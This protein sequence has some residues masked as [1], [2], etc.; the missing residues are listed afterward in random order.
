MTTA[1]DD[2]RVLLCL[3]TKHYLTV[4]G[5]RIIACTANFIS[6][7]EFRP[8]HPGLSSLGSRRIGT[9]LVFQ[10]VRQSVRVS[11]I[12]RAS[13]PYV[14]HAMPFEQASYLDGLCQF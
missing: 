10:S 3:P 12:V 13:V 8:E 11:V 6:W 1:E 2:G 14:P 4:R 7:F 9:R 5:S